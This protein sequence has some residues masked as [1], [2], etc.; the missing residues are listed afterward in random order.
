MGKLVDKILGYVF[1]V[2]LVLVI[3]SP[4]IVIFIATGGIND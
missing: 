3:L 2:L 4:Y 1:A